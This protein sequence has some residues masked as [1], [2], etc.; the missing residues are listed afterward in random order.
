[1]QESPQRNIGKIKWHK[2]LSMTMS[3]M[4]KFILNAINNSS[5][6]YI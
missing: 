5:E 6:I 3:N 4:H 1:M 2:T